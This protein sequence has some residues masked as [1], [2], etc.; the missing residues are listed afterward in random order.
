MSESSVSY[1]NPKTHG[2]EVK[3]KSATTKKKQEQSIHRTEK[4]SVA[5]AKKKTP[6]APK[7]SNGDISHHPPFPPSLRICGKQP[8]LARP[9]F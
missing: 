1:W 8:S 9:G 5:L 3:S 6:H 7:E 4:K 2:L